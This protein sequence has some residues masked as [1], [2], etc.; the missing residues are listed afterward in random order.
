MRAEVGGGSVWDFMSRFNVYPVDDALCLS[1]CRSLSLSSVCSPTHSPTYQSFTHPFILFLTFLLYFSLF[2]SGVYVR[3]CARVP[4]S[5]FLS[6]SPLHS[7]SGF[8]S[9][10][11]FLFYTHTRAHAVTRSLSST[12]SQTHTRTKSLSLSFSLTHTH[13][14]SLPLSFSLFLSLSLSL[15]LLH[16]YSDTHTHSHSHTF[17]PFHRLIHSF[18]LSRVRAALPLARVRARALFSLVLSPFLSFLFL[19]FQILSLLLSSSPLARLLPRRLSLT[20]S[21][22]LFFNSC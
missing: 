5:F 1:H 11:L 7:L 2:L 21:L 22:P 8:L 16:T 17:S 19:S 13:F 6:L 9:I 3:A 18:L 4:L 12:H 20:R 15:S 10:S 14:F